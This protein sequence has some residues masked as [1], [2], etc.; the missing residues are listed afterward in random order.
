MRKNLIMMSW[1]SKNYGLNCSTKRI[2]S[3]N[4]KTIGLRMRSLRIDWMNSSWTKAN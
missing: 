2:P 1:N 3:L 4:W